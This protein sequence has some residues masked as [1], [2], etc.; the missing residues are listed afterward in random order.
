MIKFQSWYQGEVS[1]IEKKVYQSAFV[2][3]VKYRGLLYREGVYLAHSF[4]G[5]K[6]EQQ[7]AGSHE[8][9]PGLCCLMAGMCVSLCGCSLLFVTDSLT[10]APR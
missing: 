2:A 10:G 6:S 5:W 7:D 4:G 9:S 1:T 3:I 8:G